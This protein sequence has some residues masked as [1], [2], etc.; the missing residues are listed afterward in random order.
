MSRRYLSKSR[1][2]SGLQCPKRL[3]LEVYHPE[4]AVVDAQ[5]QSA[6]Q[7]GHR[8]GAVAR[9]LWP[10][11]H[12]IEHDQDLNAALAETAHCLA[13]APGRPLFEATF[14]HDGVLVRADVLAG[15]E[16]IEVKASTG[17]KEHHVQDCAIQTW[18]VGGAWRTPREV[19]LAHVD[20]DFVY[21]GG[22]DYL[23]LFKLADITAQVE[24]LLPSVP[25]W[26]ARCRDAL[27]GPCPEREIGE[28]CHSPFDCP[29]I[30]HCA[31]PQPEYPVSILP[32]G[33]AVAAELLAEGIADVRGI[34]PGRLSKPDHERVR[35]VT[36][37][38]VP[39][40]RP[41]LPA[42]LAALPYPRFYL[43]FET[44]QF[45][46]PIWAGTRPYQQL[47]FQWSCHIEHSEDL[48]DHLQFLDTTGRDPASPLRR[49]APRAPRR[50]R[51][52]SGLQPLRE[53]HPHG[54]ED[55]PSGP[56][57]G[58]AGGDRTAGRSA[59]RRCARASTTRRR[60]AA[61]ASRRCCRRLRRSCPMRTS[62]RCRTASA[63]SRPIWR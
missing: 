28:H 45:A 29:F 31:P 22:G 57:R 19:R 26:I 48:L 25:D 9:T 41:D 17:V 8:V 58:L 35:T 32:R 63:P 5:T 15:S 30:A 39:E 42:F 62:A 21:P 46:V 59:A 44:V 33:G 16:L 11:G 18:V 14:R 50:R 7:G 10:G 47:P 36:V 4:L 54:P 20:R 37:A 52:D 53:D 40:L 34:P 3:Y 60:R 61:G 56:R 43:D 49:V 55:L 1:I 38:G 24:D 13:E 51:T 12:L 27:D 2:L 23:G 6:F